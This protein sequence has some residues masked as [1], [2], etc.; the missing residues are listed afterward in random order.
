MQNTVYA[1]LSTSSRVANY[2]GLRMDIDKAYK[3]GKAYT[4]VELPL[5]EKAF[6]DTVIKRGQ[7]V[8]IPSAA[9]IEPRGGSIVEIE[10]NPELAEF[11]AIQPSYKRHSD[12]GLHRPGF[13]FTAHKQIDLSTIEYV[14]RIYLY[15]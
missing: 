7:H 8:F 4:Y 2:I 6:S 15:S 14:V 13:Y 9:L 5:D 3:F 1:K 11:G 12:S 10:P